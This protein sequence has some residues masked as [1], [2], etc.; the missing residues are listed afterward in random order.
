[1]LN[2]QIRRRRIVLANGAEAKFPAL[3]RIVFHFG[4]PEPFGEPGGIYDSSGNHLPQRERNATTRYEP[5]TLRCIGIDKGLT[6]VGDTGH[7]WA[8]EGARFEPLTGGIDEPDRRVQIAGST[9]VLTESFANLKQLERRI[10]ALYFA[11]PV[12]MNVEIQEAPVIERVSGQIN[13]VDFRWEFE[14]NGFAINLATQ[15][16]QEQ[17]VLAAF[18]RHPVVDSPER[19]RIRAALQFFHVASRLRYTGHTPWEFMSEIILNLS[20]V[21]EALFPKDKGEETINAARRG[22]RVLNH[23]EIDIE[24]LFIPAMALRNQLDVG[25]VGLSALSRADRETVQDYTSLAEIQIRRLLCQVL[26]NLDGGVSTI[27]RTNASRAGPKVLQVVKR[28]REANKLDSQ[29]Y[30]SPDQ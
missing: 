8:R 19:L 11:L 22:L 23:S 27:P 14:W 28:I 1:M 16:H 7:L 5:E 12:L 17:A 29:R 30:S 26:G 18:R 21:L 2:Y 25:H 10:E 24:R 20:K 15:D 6:F 4:P 3:V 9:S 13:E